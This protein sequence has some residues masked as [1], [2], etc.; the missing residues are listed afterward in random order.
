VTKKTSVSRDELN[1]LLQ[2]LFA[3]VMPT[4]SAD[5]AAADEE[6]DERELRK[7]RAF[8]IYPDKRRGQSEQ[9]ISLLND[10]WDLLE[11]DLFAPALQH[12]LGFLC[13]N[14]F[15]DLND[16]VYGASRGAETG[17]EA[18][19]A[20]HPPPPLAKLIPCLQTEVGKLLQASGTDSYVAKYSQ[21]VGEME[22]FRNFYEAIF[23][24]PDESVG[25][26]FI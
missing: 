16:V 7:W 22:A 1:A 24:Q 11:S 2:A 20:S 8:L 3:D 21:G 23:F 25:M 15:Q 10:L 19:P 18:V 5:G 9:V 6:R 14:A 17:G 4:I 13:G 26:Q 12:S